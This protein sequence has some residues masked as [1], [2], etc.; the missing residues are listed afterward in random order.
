MSF[1]MYLLG[2]AIFIGIEIGILSGVSPTQKRSGV[3]A[4]EPAMKVC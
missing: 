2:F 1:A 4:A 3:R